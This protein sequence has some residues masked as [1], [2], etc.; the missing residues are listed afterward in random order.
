MIKMRTLGIGALGLVLSTHSLH[1]Q[2]VD[3]ECK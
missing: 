3:E 2:S 1:S